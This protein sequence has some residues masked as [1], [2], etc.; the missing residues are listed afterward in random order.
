MRKINLNNY[1]KYAEKKYEIGLEK[2]SDTTTTFTQTQNQLSALLNKA[3]IDIN[4]CQDLVGKLGINISLKIPP[5]PTIPTMPGNILPTP[6]I[7]C[8]GIPSISDLIQVDVS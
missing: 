3:D 5:L 6:S 7:S 4:V 8:S 1:T 2:W